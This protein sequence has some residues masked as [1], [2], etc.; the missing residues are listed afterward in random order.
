MLL[1]V[2]PFSHHSIVSEYIPRGNLRTFIRS[3][4]PFPW[5]LRVSYATDV[6]RAVAYLHAR[7]CIHRDLKG[8]NLLITSNDR[9]KVADF[10]FA[11]ITGRNAEE[12][13]HMTYCGTDVSFWMTLRD[14]TIAGVHVARD[15][16]GRA[17]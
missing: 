6:A 8:E 16:H 17:V 7:Q 10:G 4:A 9:L 1:T 2:S 15:H 3:H 12:M 5:R 11:R 13:K 14:L